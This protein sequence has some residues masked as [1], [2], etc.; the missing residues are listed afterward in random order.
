MANSM[1][2]AE[3]F[4]FFGIVGSGKG[5][6][7]ELLQKYLREKNPGLDIVYAYPGNEF[8]K[9]AAS[10]SHTA[11]LIKDTIEAGHLQPN[12]LTISIFSNILVQNLAA[13]SALI[14]DGYPRTLAQAEAF[15]SAMSFYGRDGIHL[16]YIEVGEEEA[17]KRMLLRGRADDTEAGIKKRFDEH[18]NQVVPAMSYFKGKEGYVTHVINGEQSV[19]GV[20]ADII[21]SLGI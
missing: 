3:T 19:E 7:V 15:E 10:G 13:E 18:M 21:A 14:V 11:S 12:F 1:K 20:H 9:I 17:K 5:T 4:V 2:K 8:R 6:Q 16:I